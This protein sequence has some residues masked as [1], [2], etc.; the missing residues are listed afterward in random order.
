MLPLYYSVG[1]VALRDGVRGFEV[2]PMGL[3][4]VAFEKVWLDE[5]GDAR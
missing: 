4:N 2:S 1:I 5:P 3:S